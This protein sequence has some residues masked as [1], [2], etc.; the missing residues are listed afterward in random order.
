MFE[1]GKCGLIFM[2]IISLLLIN[3]M[4]H[5]TTLLLLHYI[6]SLN[7]PLSIIY[8]NVTVM[9]YY[10]SNSIISGFIGYQVLY[11]VNR[12]SSHIHSPRM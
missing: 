2:E 8:Y 10:N 5:K 9:L 11:S 3:N 7:L 4:M 1:E 6:T 12:D